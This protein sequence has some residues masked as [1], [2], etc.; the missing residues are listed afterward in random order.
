MFL[1]EES[2]LGSTESQPPSTGR[3]HRALQ[4]HMYDIT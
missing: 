2:E 4:D 3:A 1:T